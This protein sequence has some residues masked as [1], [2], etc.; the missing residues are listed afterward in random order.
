MTWRPI[1]EAPTDGTHFLAHCV[2]GETDFVIEAW[3][4]GSAFATPLEELGAAS[5]VFL[6]HYMP[7]PALPKEL[8]LT[9]PEEAGQQPSAKL[10][11]A[12]E[13][14][15]GKLSEAIQRIVTSNRERFRAHI[16]P[17]AIELLGND[18]L[19]TKVAEEIYPMLPL[20]VR[21]AVKQDGFSAF[22]LKHR[23]TL[24]AALE[25]A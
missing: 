24:I 25:K 18:D 17:K 21:L 20:M 8:G 7:L 4:D 14:M 13:P 10:L 16:G 9:S 6:I 5:A 1:S 22:L 12:I 3:W 11:Q 15:K 23:G 2:G 19:V